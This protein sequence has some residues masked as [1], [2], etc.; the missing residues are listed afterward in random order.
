MSKEQA[1]KAMSK[2]EVETFGAA[3]TRYPD[4]PQYVHYVNRG[5]PVP[6]M[7]GL[8]PVADKWNPIADGG[9]GSKVHHFNDFKLNPIAA[10]GFESIYLKHRVPFDQ[11]RA[12]NFN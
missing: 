12:G 11:A 2:L 4:G 5:D 8:G 1:Q 10:H 9:K 7:F 6:G 3:A